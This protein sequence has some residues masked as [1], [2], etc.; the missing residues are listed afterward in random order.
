MTYFRHQKLNDPKNNA[1]DIQKFQ[2]LG[3]SA[4]SKKIK[5]DDKKIKA[6]NT[7]F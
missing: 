7:T 4:L 5:K 2:H 1:L 3:S 6:K